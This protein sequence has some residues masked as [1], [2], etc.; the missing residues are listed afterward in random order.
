MATNEMR[1]GCGSSIEPVLASNQKRRRVKDR[2]SSVIR[3]RCGTVSRHASQRVLNE[4][5]TRS[6][7]IFAFLGVLPFQSQRY[8]H[9]D[10]LRI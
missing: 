4:T 1:N 3:I 7:D 8:P 2:S 10:M 5:W 9:L 6:V